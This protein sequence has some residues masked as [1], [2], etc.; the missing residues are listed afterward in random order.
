MFQALQRMT[1]LAATLMA[2]GALGCASSREVVVGTDPGGT[3]GAA[4]SPAGAAV[5]T[6]SLESEL[7][8]LI[9]AQKAYYEENGYYSGDLGSLGFTAGSGVRIDVLQ[10]DGDG[11]SAIARSGDA[12][13][14][15]FSGDVRAPRGYV[16][17]P[18]RPA[19]R[20]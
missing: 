3:G 17:I 6:A 4:V 8:R 7:S 20:E 13:C 19:C 14:A 15:V 12:E 1:V 5:S 16:S 10:G 18:D 11:F 9:V 2:L